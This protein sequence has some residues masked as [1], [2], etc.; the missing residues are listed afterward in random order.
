[1]NNRIIPYLI[2]LLLTSG[3]SA[4]RS[5]AVNQMSEVMLEGSIDME[6]ETNWTMLEQ[7]IPAQIKLLEGLASTAPRNLSLLSLLAKAYGT[8]GFAVSET[9][10]LDDQLS[11]RQF[12]P[13]QEQAI[14]H[15]Q[16]GLRYGLQYLLIK[17]IKLEDLLSSQTS[18]Q[19]VMANAVDREALLFTLLNWL[20]LINM[21]KQNPVLMPHLTSVKH[22]LDELCDKDP[23]IKGGACA[24]LQGLY[25]VQLPMVMGGNPQ[26]GKDLL[27]KAQ[28]DYP[29]NLFFTLALLQ[30]YA[31]P[32]DEGEFF[33]QYGQQ[34]ERQ[35]EIRKQAQRWPAEDRRSVSEV[36]SA[37][38]AKRWE[39]IKQHQ[40]Q[41]FP[42]QAPVP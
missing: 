36:W 19:A 22:R 29:D 11:G 9:L 4:L 26:Q 21:Q 27:L 14:S 33:Y 38:A 10:L 41:L 13:H 17:G 32:L 1:M 16:R 37:I 31:I 12:S 42:Q 20:G 3:C 35:L 15:Y 8:Y 23:Q 18:I 30:Y 28:G 2:F 24:L 7:S 25:Q 34:L 6:R 5:V 40:K 39:I